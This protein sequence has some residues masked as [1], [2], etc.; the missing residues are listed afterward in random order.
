MTEIVFASSD[1]NISKQISSLVKSNQLRPL[2]PRVYTSNMDDNDAEIVR[3]NLWKLIAHLFPSSTLSYRS[4]LEFKSSPAGN[5]YLTGKNRRT[6]DW[7]GI[8][9]RF[10]KGPEKLEDDHPIIKG[11]YVASLERACLENLLSSRL[12]KGERRNVEQHILEER[13]LN[14]LNTK[15]EKSLNEF[16]DRAKEIAQKADWEKAYQKLNKIIGAILSTKT[17]SS[18]AS[19]LAKSY[20][21]G[22]SY[23]PH[24]LDL[25][26][27]LIGELRASSFVDR[28]QKTNQDQVF[29]NFAF[30]ESYF[31]NY[32]EGTTF[33]VEEAEEIVYKGQFIANRTGDS[34]D[35]QATYEICSNRFEMGIIPKNGVTLLELLRERHQIVMRGRPD[36]NPG[37]FK[38]RANRAGNSF[39]VEPSLVIGTLKEGYE[40]INALKEPFARAIYM[41]FLI[42]EVHPFNDGNGR[43]ARIMMNA[44][45]VR[46]K[47]SKLIIPTVYRE[48][49]ILNLKRLT[50]KKDAKAY[51]RMMEKIHGFSHW[52]DPKDSSVMRNQLESSNAFKDSEEGAIKMPPLL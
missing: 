38:S 44:E 24:R 35:V 21:L 33:T 51:I 30:Y 10:T 46:A 25:F 32:I 27:M 7:P 4:A 26:Q 2:L 16:R 13:L 49:Y 52:L 6:Y 1:P 19:S 50:Q 11:L 31:S 3:R 5:L 43:I 40:L 22:E 45:L 29:L 37:A 23:D 14:I 36:K 18:L 48:D 34:H 9:L 47:Q 12:V 15:G 17:T 41:M 8:S 28:P 42:S 20:A 39:F